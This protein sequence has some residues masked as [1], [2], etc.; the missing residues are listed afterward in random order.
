M[1]LTFFTGQIQLVSMFVP[2]GSRVPAISNGE[3]SL[4]FTTQ[5]T[6]LQTPASTVTFSFP[7][8][9]FVAGTTPAILTQSPAAAF[10]TSVGFNA[11]L[12]QFVLTLA[13]GADRA[14]GAFNVTINTLTMGAIRA[15]ECRSNVF[16]SSST[17]IQSTNAANAGLLVTRGSHLTT[18][19]THADCNRRS[20]RPGAEPG[21][22][23]W[24]C[25]RTTS[26]YR[27]VSHHQF[28]N[29]DRSCQL[30]LHYHHMAQ[31]LPVADSRSADSSIQRASSHI[32]GGDSLPHS[33]HHRRRHSHCTSWFIHHN[34]DRSHNRVTNSVATMQYV[35]CRLDR[36]YLRSHHHGSRGLFQ[37]SID[38][39][40][41]PGEGR[42]CRRFADRPR[43]QLIKACDNLI[44]HS[45]GFNFGSNYQ[46][47]SLFRPLLP[48]SFCSRTV[49]SGWPAAFITQFAFGANPVTFTGPTGTF[50]TTFNVQ[51][52]GGTITV[53]GAGAPRGACESFACN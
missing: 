44:H 35:R 16:A 10:T 36:L 53:G 39:A 3:V 8:G 25:C 34:F 30:E 23:T 6:L 2:R 15:A 29:P 45:N 37:L 52:A 28:Q 40:Q 50:S 32:L 17:D 1:M 47:V 51:G 49:R 41:G 19:G 26:C 12:G 20:W 46:H 48:L 14:A 9:F 11:A 27:Q 18:P 13:S 24:C 4:F 42:E 5:T 22:V 31:R 21:F 43:S 7:V 33:C 38:S